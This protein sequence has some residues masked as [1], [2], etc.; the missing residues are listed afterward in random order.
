ML[1]IAENTVITEY[2]K[3]DAEL[4]DVA[5]CIIVIDSIKHKLSNTKKSHP[6]KELY[7]NAD[8]PGPFYELVHFVFCTIENHSKKKQSSL[9]ADK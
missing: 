8:N 9:N 3:I 7:T 4:D 6:L 5:K 1:V 2:N